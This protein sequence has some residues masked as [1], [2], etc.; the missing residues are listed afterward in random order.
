MKE[1]A[2]IYAASRSA[3]NMKED[4]R[5][6]R[7]EKT[8]KPARQVTVPEHR[9]VRKNREPLRCY[10]CAC[11]G[12]MTR[13][14]PTGRPQPP[15]QRPRDS[16]QTQGHACFVTDEPNQVSDN[17]SRVF[18]SCGIIYDKYNG[19]DLTTNLPMMR[20]LLGNTSVS[21]LRDTGSTAILVR[22]RLVRQ[23]QL[24]GKSKVVVMIN[25]STFIAPLAHC[26]L[27]SPVIS[28]E[29]ELSCVPNLIC[30]VVVGNVSGVHEPIHDC[31]D[32][33]DERAAHRTSVACVV[34]TRAQEISREKPASPIKVPEIGDIN[35][36]SDAFKEAQVEDDSLKVCC[37]RTRHFDKKTRMRS[38]DV[39]DQVLVML[40]TSQNKLMMQWK[41]PYIVERKVGVADYHVRIGEHAKVFHMN[42]LRKYQDR[43]TAWYGIVLIRTVIG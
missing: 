25:S 32:A 33:N 11:I 2:D 24:T 4:Y 15:S 35:A 20:G 9:T 41:G 40:P 22:S 28:G 38:L 43:K 14:C 8:M 19:D 10:L 5:T 34:E 6:D 31:G 26:H 3:V 30:D 16:R 29:V 27:D 42:M 1:L 18:A 7:S 13:N 17:A 23:D 39:G 37:K 21:V 12:H 36:T